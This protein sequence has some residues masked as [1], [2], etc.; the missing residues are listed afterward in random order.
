M[1][2]ADR[3]QIRALAIRAT[4]ADEASV[5][6]L[7]T[8]ACEALGGRCRMCHRQYKFVR[9]RECGHLSKIGERVVDCNSRSCFLSAAHPRNCGAHG[10]RCN[11]RRY[12]GQPERLV[13]GEVRR[14]WSCS[15]RY[16]T[17]VAQNEGK[18]IS[19]TP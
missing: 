4:S 8:I 7:V 18:C 9:A 12:Y 2:P 3:T 19:C 17:L 1:M 6:Q 16:L 11:C 13:M 14:R 10:Q 15:L 5:S